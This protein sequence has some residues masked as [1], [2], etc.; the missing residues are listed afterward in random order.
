MDSF[1]WQSDEYS[2]NSSREKLPKRYDAL[3][4]ASILTGTN[5]A[6]RMIPRWEKE[7][8]VFFGSGNQMMKKAM[9]SVAKTN[10]KGAIELWKA[11]AS[12][13]KNGKI[14]YRVYHNIA[15]AYEIIGNMDNAIAYAKQAAD[16]YSELTYASEED[17]FLI[18]LSY[19]NLV[20]R[21]KEMEVIKRQ[22]VN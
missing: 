22:L 1:L 11:V 9:D 8:R 21:K 5:I 4:D 19:Q 20:Q 2:L 17:G 13:A 14:K 18:L 6:E 15:N 16:S 3:V 7:D 12:T 10:W